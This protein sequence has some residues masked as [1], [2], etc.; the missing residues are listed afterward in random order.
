MTDN[1]A[2][3]PPELEAEL[4]AHWSQQEGAKEQAKGLT[5]SSFLDWLKGQ[6]DLLGKNPGL[7]EQIVQIGPALMTHL[8]R[9]LT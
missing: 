2:K 6:S 4:K 5:W 7:M 3:L 8:L 1:S 9:I